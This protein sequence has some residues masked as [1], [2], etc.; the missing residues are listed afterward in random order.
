ML[1]M[2][3]ILMELV[4]SKIRHG[5]TFTVKRVAPTTIQFVAK[6]LIKPHTEN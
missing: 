6:K 3:D 1:V 5:G 2:M 4:L